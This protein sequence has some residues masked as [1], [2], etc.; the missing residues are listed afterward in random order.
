MYNELCAAHCEKQDVT[1]QT[2]TEYSAN[3][4]SKYSNNVDQQQV[5]TTSITVRDT[6]FSL[7]S[8]LAFTF[9]TSATT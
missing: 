9:L 8:V 6:F 5:I 7:C 1:D 4:C 3:F 2:R